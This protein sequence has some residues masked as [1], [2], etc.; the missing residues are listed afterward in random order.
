MII[1]SY[2]KLQFLGKMLKSDK[3]NT[4]IPGLPGFKKSGKVGTE[5]KKVWEPLLNCKKVIMM[6]NQ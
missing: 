2:S 5:T 6:D 3:S 4:F 1:A